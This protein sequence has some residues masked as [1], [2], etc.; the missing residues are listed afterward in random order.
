M[1]LPNRDL[2]ITIRFCNKNMTQPG[3]NPTRKLTHYDVL[4]VP[5]TASLESIK[6]SYQQ[7]ARR[8][9]PDK[10]GMYPMQKND[11][12]SDLD[13]EFLR[14]QSAWECLRDAA[15]RKEYDAGL[16]M[17]RT[18][19]TK[20]QPL[21][22]NDLE[23]VEEEDT[24]DLCYLYTCRCGEEIWLPQERLEA[25]GRDDDQS[26]VYITCDGCSLVFHVTVPDES[27][28]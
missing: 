21:T 8:L 16:S 9:H 27:C 18:E 11:L 5:F 26:N 10:R 20:S 4:Q 12:E 6:T 23:L 1:I 19:R 2:R 15:S 22:F 3:K 17:Q 14:I 25:A 13:H 28:V 7:Q 24:G